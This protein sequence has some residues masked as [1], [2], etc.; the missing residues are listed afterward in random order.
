[1]CGSGACVCVCLCV[2]VYVWMRTSVLTKSRGSCEGELTLPL[3]D[4]LS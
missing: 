4:T 1:M 2:C 3:S